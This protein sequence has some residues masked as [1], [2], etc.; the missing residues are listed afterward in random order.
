METDA[1]GEDCRI[2]LT[3]ITFEAAERISQKGA[4]QPAIEPHKL[5]QMRRLR[6]LPAERPVQRRSDLAVT[7]EDISFA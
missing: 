6:W 7:R 4:V 5:R 3:G 1:R 2:L